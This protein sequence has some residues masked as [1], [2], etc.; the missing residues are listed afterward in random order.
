MAKAIENGAWVRQLQWRCASK[1][2]KKLKLTCKFKEQ[3]L[4]LV[5]RLRLSLR[6]G[7]EINNGTHIQWSADALQQRRISGAYVAWKEP[8]SK[9]HIL[10]DSIY[11][12]FLKRWN[13]RDR[14]QINKRQR[15]E[16]EGGGDYEQDQ[17]QDGVAWRLHVQKGPDL[18]ECS[19][20]TVLKLFII[21]L[22]TCVL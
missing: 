6:W 17:L 2:K 4:P 8:D 1:K 19:V 22:W 11:I 18:D 14:K 9:S 10:C 7:G 21:C 3:K 12:A 15:L 13:Y 16:V 5:L 20:V